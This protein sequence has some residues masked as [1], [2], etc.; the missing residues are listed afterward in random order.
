M[1]TTTTDRLLAALRQHT[2]VASLGWA[3]PPGPIAGGFLAEMYTLE[4][5]DPPPHLTGRL[6]ARIMPDPATAAY[7]TAIQRHLHHGVPV[8]AVRASGP[9]GEHLDRA[10]SVMDHAPGR[11]LLEGLGALTAI[12]H[13]PTLYRRLPVLLAAAAASVHRCP[14]DGLDETLAGSAR[15]PHVRDFLDRLAGRATMVGRPDLAHMAEVLAVAA[16]TGGVL[17]HGDLHPFNLLVDGERWTLIDWSTAVVADPHY[18]LAF[19]TLM[20]ANPPLGGPGPLQAIVRRVGGRIANQFLHT[21]HHLTGTQ[22]DHDRLRWGRQ[23]HALR[24]TV[25]IAGW[26][27]SGGLDSHVGHPWL[28]MRSAL[29]TALSF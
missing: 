3:S 25:E 15:R 18:D 2:A 20:L 27:T 22:L 23:V 4:F 1:T 10:W 21:Y 12:R 8:P 11:P 13:A 29:E 9:A 16:P 5:A 14:L 19:T 24:A 28:A 7:E 26:E 17:C 6:V